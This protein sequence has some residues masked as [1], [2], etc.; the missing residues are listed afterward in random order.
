MTSIPNMP[1]GEYVRLIF[2][3]RYGLGESERNRRVDLRRWCME[4]DGVFLAAAALGKAN[5]Q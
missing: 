1:E 5:V 4:R 2:A 3:T